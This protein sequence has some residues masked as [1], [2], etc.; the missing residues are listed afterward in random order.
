MLSLKILLR[1]GI[2]MEISQVSHSAGQAVPFWLFYSS[3]SPI[4]EV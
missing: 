3:Y 4:S 2:K 1:N